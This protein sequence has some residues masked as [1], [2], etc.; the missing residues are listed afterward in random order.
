MKNYKKG[1]LALSIVAAMPF[2]MA[3]T[4][5]DARIHV[6]TF[7]DEDGENP[8]ACSLREALTAA[9]INKPYGGCS[10]G[11]TNSSVTDAIVLKKGEYVLKRSLTPASQVTITGAE[12][13]DW[14]KKDAISGDYPATLKATSIIKG[15]G[16]FTLFDTAS[17]KGTLRL[18]NVALDGG[19]GKRGGAILAGGTVVLNSVEVKNSTATEIGGAIY[20]AGVGSSLQANDSIFENNQAPKG[21]VLAMSCIDNLI[22]TERDIGFQRSSILNNGN[23]NTSNVLEFCGNAKVELANNTITLNKASSSQ[24][25]IIKYTADSRPNTTDH[26]ILS[27]SSSLVAQNNTIIDNT[28]YATFLYDS[29]GMKSLSYNILAYNQGQSCRHLLGAF[30]DPTVTN[31]SFNFNAVNPVASST[32]YCYLPYP[33]KGD[34]TVDLSKFAK[35]SVILP[36]QV[37]S[38]FSSF[39]PV[40]FLNPTTTNPLLNIE[41]AGQCI[42]VDQLN[43]G[44]YLSDNYLLTTNTKR[45]DIGSIEQNWVTASDL[46]FMNT[47]QV[48]LLDSFKLERDFFKN[49]IE[50]STTNPDF[51]PYYKVRQQEYSD[52]LDKYPKTFKYRQVY[53]DVFTNSQPHEIVNGTGASVIQH[54]DQN[55]YTVT[56][57]ALGTGA[58]VFANRASN[59]LP[60]TPDANLKCEWNQ[61]IQK[62]VMYRTDGIVN[63]AGDFGYCKY[64]LALKSNPTVKSSGILQAS[65]T[66]ISPVATPDTYTLRWGTDQRTRLNLL[67]NDHDDGDGKST[68]AFYPKGKT[69]FYVD[70]NG[71]SAPIKIGKIDS[72]LLFEAQYEAPCPDE[73]GEICYGGEMYITPKN[74]FNKF[75]FSFNY[76]VFDADGAI[77][78][79]VLVR[80][81]ST[82]TTTDDTRGDQKAP[83]ITDGK[84]G[85]GSVGFFTLFGLS[86]LALLRRRSLKKQS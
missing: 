46:S 4:T 34:T 38:S 21:A 44:R 11:K 85:G 2:V 39:K 42:A 8:A 36:L 6:T 67:A 65:F 77:S 27:S 10:T 70:A 86:A 43:K 22:F 5:E 35:S 24:G 83:I 50:S 20:L 48:G 79:E 23:A 63:Q 30:A 13:T 82:A 12:A 69:P 78:N 58:D 26:S 29:V 37:S 16:T 81:I 41:N 54:F 74:S 72:N 76:Q 84:G 45:C 32:D 68:D 9:E 61:D 57:E 73:S 19:G 53:F 62:V 64:T 25:S 14:S 40:Y 28:A 52:F 49:L 71:V 60:S 75:N 17:G 56:V 80:L 66:N 59:N 51:I 55:L 18:D 7:A 3:N 15:N 33:D 47:S 1:I 31:L